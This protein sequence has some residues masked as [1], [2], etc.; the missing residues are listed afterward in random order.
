MVVVA[1]LSFP[2]IS[3][4]D[5]NEVASDDISVSLRKAAA[6]IILQSYSRSLSLW[7]GGTSGA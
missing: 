5:P 1:A 3:L 7:G 4:T 2:G 6:V